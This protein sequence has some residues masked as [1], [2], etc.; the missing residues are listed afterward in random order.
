VKTSLRKAFVRASIAAAS[1][2]VLLLPSASSVQAT[3]TLDQQIPT[4][5]ITPQAS[6]FIQMAQMA[7]TFTAG[8]TGQM[9]NVALYIGSS[10]FV[11]PS[12]RLEVWTVDT[13]RTT[14]SP[15]GTP[16][17]YQFQLA[18]A[19]NARRGWQTVP[20]N[21]AVPVQAG[22]QYAL[23]LKAASSPLLQ[24]WYFMGGWTLAGSNMWLCCPWT[25][26]TTRD[27]AFQTYVAGGSTTPPANTPPTLDPPV[28]DTVLTPE[29]AVPSNTGTYSDPDSGDTVGVTASSGS[30][31]KTG[32]NHGTWSWS[33]APVDEGGLVQTVTIT[34]NDGHN[35][36]VTRTFTVSVYAVHPTVTINPAGTAAAAMA[37]ASAINEGT[38]L[39]FNGTASSPDSADNTAGFTYAWT[40]TKDG[41]A[42]PAS[43]AG[44][45]FGFTPNDEGAYVVTLSATDDGN[46]TGTTSF[47]V[48]VGDVLPTAVISAVTP[49]LT[50]PRIVLP[51]QPV[52]FS[53]TFT[54]PGTADAHSATWNFGD[55]ASATGWVVSHYYTQAG[56][57]TVTLTVSQGEDPGVGTAQ[58]TVAVLTPAQALGAIAGYVQNLPGLNAG[59][60]NSLAAKLNSASAS[61][62]RGDSNASTNQLN[63]FLNELR[64]D[65]NT[66]KV[67]DADAAVLQ[68][69]IAEV[70]GALGN[71]NPFLDFWPLG[72]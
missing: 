28:A 70:K 55:G 47:A 15:V 69:D 5:G 65:V 17:A 72:I 68:T 20:L 57:Y 2:A 64:A 22:H 49:S 4:A 25:E 50:A 19:N 46:M 48:S 21:P 16:P 40:V 66:G 42:Y 39:T 38:A 56:S 32:T 14:L 23:V 59:Q 26:D 27:F 33:G 29:G 10:S 9:D 1:A 30:L 12:F 31:T 37:A 62:A 60:K 44:A 53:G 43:G 63:A 35:P 36:A 52:T 61:A 71:Y 58:A 6:S 67:S 45:T 13:T 8:V 7:Q 18:L 51:Y 3:D 41:A 54:D 34:A 24:R 11:N